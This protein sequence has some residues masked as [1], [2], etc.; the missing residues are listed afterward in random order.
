M[1]TKKQDKKM[2]SIFFI[3]IALF[4][5]T[6][7]A[8]AFM[9]H[10][11]GEIFEGILTG[12]FLFDGNLN[13]TENI[14]AHSSPDSENAIV[15][16]SYVDANSGG[17]GTDFAGL[18]SETYYFSNSSSILK[19]NSICANEYPES[20]ICLRSEVKG[21]AEEFGGE[22][23]DSAFIYDDIIPEQINNGTVV[24]KDETDDVYK[25][26]GQLDMEI[27]SDG[28]PMFVY[29]VYHEDN[30]NNR[31]LHFYKCYDEMCLNGDFED[32]V[33]MN[34]G[35]YGPKISVGSDGNPIIVA[36]DYA[37]GELEFF[38]CSNNGCS[39]G[40]ARTL[41]TVN[42]RGA[43]IING[44]DG[45]PVISY[46]NDYYYSP[47]LYIYKC[48]DLS[49]SSGT[50]RILDSD[51]WESYGST[52]IAIGS[53]GFPIISYTKRST[54]DLAIYKCNN[55][56]CSSGSSV[57]IEDSNGEFSSIAIGEDGFPIISYEGNG[58]EV[59]KCSTL[60]CSNGNSRRIGEGSLYA[61]TSIAV[62]NEGRPY[63]TWRDYYDG[64]S[65]NFY[66]CNDSICSG[67]NKRILVPDTFG[68]VSMTIGNDNLPLVGYFSSLGDIRYMNFYRHY[69]DNQFSI[70]NKDFSMQKPFYALEQKLACCR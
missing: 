10:N 59:Y 48:N 19:A 36:H 9:G 34:G 13:V 57:S 7:S 62:D 42:R 17:S 14:V 37:N 55:V 38:Q 32:Y 12:N 65:L 16:K 8:Y 53:D 40:T 30:N 66:R 21:I 25:M 70:L 18:T 61:Y 27:A 69:E 22:V 52:S 15:T 60:D 26:Q 29:S 67:G 23:S 28:L 56:E 44:S 43:D 49:C 1:K 58:I 47:N 3:V 54:G 2:R 33:S 68:H 6:L 50:S 63:I 20:R 39:S 35:S 64:Y 4:L 51:G 41:D 45:Y 24:D 5:C 46:Y 11:A 31:R